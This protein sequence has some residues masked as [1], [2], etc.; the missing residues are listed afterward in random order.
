[1]SRRFL[2]Y[3]LQMSTVLS[4][5]FLNAACKVVD[6]MLAFLLCNGLNFLG[7]GCFQSCNS[8]W[9]ILVNV[10]LE[11]PPQEEIW[12]I[13]VRRVRCPFHFSFAADETLSKLFTE[14][15]HG[16]ISSVRRGTILLESLFFL[17][18]V[19]TLIELS[20]KLLKHWNVVL[21]CHSY[22][23][24]VIIFKEKWSDDTM[25]GNGNP[26]CAFFECEGRPAIL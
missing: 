9:V 25:L 8:E 2:D 17:I 13:Q 21:F 22:C 18:K 20:P 16:D 23:Y 12:R 6:N 11:E 3:M 10:V 4:K 14:P 5:A 24:T 7:N 1:M 15:S 26:C 19:L